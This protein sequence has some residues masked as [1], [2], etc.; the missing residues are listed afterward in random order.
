MLRVRSCLLGVGLLA[1][2]APLPAQ[3]PVR[4]A[5]PRIVVRF[6][7]SRSSTPLD[8]RLLVIF[9]TDT[10]AEP[11]FQISDISETQIIFGQD[12]DGWRPGTPLTL[13]ASAPGYPLRLL[14]DIPPGRYRVQAVLNRYETFHRADGHVVKLP[15]D[16]GEGQQWSLKP[17]NLYSAP[18]WLVVGPRL[19]PMSTGAALPPATT[20]TLDQEIPAI[21][22]PAD[23]RYVRHE[24][25]KS[26]LLSDFWGRPMYLGAHVLL[27]EGFD[28]HPTARYP[29]VIDHGHFPATFEG[30][31]ET[32]P[33]P[34]LAP[35]YSERFHLPAYNRIQQEEAYRFYQEWTGPHFPRAL[36]IQIQHPTPYYDDSYAVNS[37][38][39][40]PYG[41]AIMHELVPYLEKKYRGIGQGYARFAYGG[42]TGGWEAM[43]VQLFYPDDFNGIWAACPDPI[44][45]RQYTVVNIYDDTNAYWAAS[46]WK[47]IERPAHRDYLGNISTTIL[48]SNQLE[49]VV[50]SRGRSGGQWDVWQSVYSPID[51]DGYPQP[52]WNKR[53]GVIDHAVAQFWRDHYD[54]G[55]MLRRDWATLGP[56]V[57]GK[58]H[59]YVGEADNYFLNNAVYLAEETLTSATN[60][61]ADAE[62]D[63]ES[64]AEH[65]WNGDHTRPNAYSR[66][67]YAQM[68]VPRIM[69]Q[70]RKNHPVDVDTLSWRY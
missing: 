31:R 44:D 62:V 48:Q 25:I 56:K 63:Y 10:S 47:R 21:A 65:C 3:L 69:D 14:G 41:D 19:R 59:I 49:D 7:A 33:D 8:G 58:L 26:K 60:P 43:A 16:M 11:R 61:A 12:V 23:T 9:S 50:A 45:F 64:R 52:I 35:E 22:P 51:A 36:L 38:A 40:G 13:S 24:R 54:L 1:G 2:A 37:A 20:I 42:S 57:R 39:N 27:P 55:W 30:W 6:P 18:Q 46:R 29:L 34:D 5:G 28:S 53:T 68:F 32:P 17:G 4:A 70:I 67:R 15:P 66:L